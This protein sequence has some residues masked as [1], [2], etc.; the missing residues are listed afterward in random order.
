MG[1][2]DVGDVSVGRRKVFKEH[3]TVND[4][5]QIMQ[6]RDGLTD[7]Q[8]GHGDGAKQAHGRWPNENLGSNEHPGVPTEAP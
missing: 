7:T 8:R 3:K 2:P 5:R 6:S 4:E 1:Q